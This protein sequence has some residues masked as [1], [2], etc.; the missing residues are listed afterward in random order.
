MAKTKYAVSYSG[1]TARFSDYP[2]AMYFARDTSRD[3]L[4]LIEVWASDGIVGQFDGG[5]PTREFESHWD[6]VRALA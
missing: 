2:D 6:S 5:E 3:R 1:K 4:G